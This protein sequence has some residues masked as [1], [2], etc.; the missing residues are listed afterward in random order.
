MDCWLLMAGKGN[1]FVRQVLDEG[2]VAVS[3]LAVFEGRSAIC[4]LKNCDDKRMLLAVDG[5]LL[6]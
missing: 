6:T 3:W 5:L 4:L 2:L 1:V